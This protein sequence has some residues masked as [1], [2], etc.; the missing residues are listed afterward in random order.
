MVRVS[1]ERDETVPLEVVDNP[2]HVLPP[3]PDLPGD[4]RHRLR[5]RRL[6]DRAKDLPSRTRQTKTFDQSITSADQAAVHLE[7][8]EGELLE[9]VYRKL[10][11]CSIHAYMLGITT[12]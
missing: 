6:H 7:D 5:S 3:T 4:P 9:L 11:P 10:A 1:F 2:L 8:L 12:S